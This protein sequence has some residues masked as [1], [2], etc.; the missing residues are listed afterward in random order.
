M[1]PVTPCRLKMFGRV[2]YRRAPSAAAAM[3]APR[4]SSMVGSGVGGLAR[5]E[6]GGPV[7]EGPRQ[8]RLSR[9]GIGRS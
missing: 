1:A 9:R 4:Q 7:A 2:R 3:T 8:L 5:L 6:A